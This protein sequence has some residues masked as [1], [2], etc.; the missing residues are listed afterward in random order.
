MQGILGG[1]GV[2]PWSGMDVVSPDLVRQGL[3]IDPEQ[4][5]GGRL[6]PPGVSGGG[7]GGGWGGGWGG[8]GGGGGGAAGVGGGVAGC[9]LGA[10]GAGGKAAGGCVLVAGGGR[11]AARRRHSAGGAMGRRADRQLG[12]QPCCRG[13]PAGR[14]QAHPDAPVSDQRD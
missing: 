13:A 14:R 10:G 4:S 3:H 8:G 11:P 2:S 1:R 12:A 7:G 6:L 9:G 5:R